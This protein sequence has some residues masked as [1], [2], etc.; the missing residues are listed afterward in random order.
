MPMTSPLLA[1]AGQGPGGQQLIM[2]IIFFAAI[3]FIMQ[4]LIFRP[5]KKKEQQRRDMLSKVQ[6]GDKVVTIGGIH[7]EVISVKD[8]YVVLLVDAERGTTMKFSRHAV[9]NIVTDE[10]S[11]EDEAKQ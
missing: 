7:G 9:H 2:T 6:R 5:Q 10:T 1:A 4:F 11:D 3:F 8:K